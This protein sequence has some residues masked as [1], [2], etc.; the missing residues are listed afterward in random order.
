ME[1]DNRMRS[2]LIVAASAALLSA[3]AFAET[4]IIQQDSP[5]TTGSVVVDQVPDEV[6]TYVR[7]NPLDAAPVLEGRLVNGT[8]VPPDVNLAPVRG[9][10]GYSYFY[11]DGAPVIV[12]SQRRVIRIVR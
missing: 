10:D 2:F 11:S 5:D 8:I 9:H 6:T 3:P 12:D 4:V 1:E 7:E